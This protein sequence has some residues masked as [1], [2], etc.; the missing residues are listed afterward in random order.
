MKVNVLFVIYLAEFFLE[1]EMFQVRE[2][3]NTHFLFSTFFPKIGPFI[4]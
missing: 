2:R 3:R 4:G 1:W